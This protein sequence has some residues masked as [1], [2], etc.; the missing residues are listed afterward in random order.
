MKNRS[1]FFPLLLIAAGVVWLLIS[2]NVIPPSNLWALT[3]IWPYVLI[4]LGVGLLLSAQW[5]VAGR[6]V[7]VLVIIG[8]VAA[9]IYA[10]QL[11]WAG[12]SDW[13]NFDADFGGSV[14][15]SGKI[16]TETRNVQDFL[17]ISIEYPAEIVVQQGKSESVKVEAD[18]NLLPQLITEMRNGTL[19][20]KNNEK[21]WSKRVNPSEPVKIIITVKDL[22]E[23]DFSSAGTLRVEGLKSDDFKIVLSGAGEVIFSK[24]NVRNFESILSGAGNIK[25]DGA[26]D[27]VKLT[28]SGFGNFEAPE[29]T[30]MTADVRITG[31]GNAVMRVKNELTA[32]VSGAGS[33]E[34]YGSPHVIKNISGA[35]SVNQAGN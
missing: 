13:W 30:S 20:I 35:G 2:L 12:G 5:A 26:S 24:I 16:V 27:N 3:H 31:A 21:D 17:A 9:V 19:F 8:A 34:Y 14:Q 23:V 25:A 18:D 4:T 11:G 22:H 1:L 32:T 29:L 15:G 7:S 28:I 33:V 6:A 10:P